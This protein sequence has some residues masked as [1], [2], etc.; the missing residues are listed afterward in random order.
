MLFQV[1]RV[2][3]TFNPEYFLFGNLVL[4]PEE[5]L[6]F[7][8]ALLVV[9]TPLFAWRYNQLVFA[10]FNPTLARTRGLKITLNNYLFIVIL[11]LAV[12]LSIKAVGALLINALLVVPAAAAAN[13]AR[14]LRQMFWLTI[15]FCLGSGLLGFAFRNSVEFQVGGGQPVP[16]GP[17]GVI[18]VTSVALFFASMIFSAVWARFAPVLGFVPMPRVR[19]HIHDATCADDHFGTCP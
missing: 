9:V 11:A 12:N 3:S 1:L 17:S 4:I 13:V 14:N 10:S 18:V 19:R 16:F 2:K 6:L 5:D 8:I 7:L 15:A